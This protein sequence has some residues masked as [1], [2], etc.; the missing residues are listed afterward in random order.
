VDAYA[1][2]KQELE[3]LINSPTVGSGAN[4]ATTRLQLID[5]ILF[6]CLGWHPNEAV[7]E[8]HYNG[9]YVDYAIGKPSTQFILEAKKEG[10]SFTLPVGIEGRHSVSLKTILEN[11]ESA[12]AIKQ[13]LAYCQERGVPIAVASNGHQLIAFLASRQDGVPPLGGDALVFSSLKEMHGDFQILWQHLSK[14]GIAVKNLQRTLAKLS[15][16]IRPPEKLSNTI[17][18]YPGFRPRTELETDLKTLGQLFI[19]D[20]GQEKQITDDFVKSCYYSSGTLSQYALVS[21]EILRARYSIIKDSMSVKPEPVAT[22]KGVNPK[23]SA[24]IITAALS[25]RPIVLL[26]DVGVGKSMFLQHFIRV[27]AKDL[28]GK[29]LVLYVDFVR[30]PTFSVNLPKYIADRL[31]A[32]LSEHYDIE[33]DESSFVRS[34]YNRE[35]N[36]FRKTIDGELLDSDPTQYRTNELRMLKEHVADSAEHLRRSLEYVRATSQR[37]PLI[38]FDNIDQRPTDFQEQ[39]FATAHSVAETWPGTVFVSLRPSTFFTSQAHGP[40]AA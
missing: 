8:D 30:E 10:I 29:S 39:I 6:N 13:V 37:S 22:K 18:G 32:Q 7:T 15:T 14:S 24:E 33:I 31:R 36:K 16:S 38:V 34:V 12:K 19:Q 21:K 23:L 2:A 9:T 1:S 20:L 35:I 17:D 11:P 5:A 26:G 28:L 25:R 27:D 40:L 4:E 3:N